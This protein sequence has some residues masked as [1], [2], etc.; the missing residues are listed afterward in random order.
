MKNHFYIIENKIIY[1]I[2]LMILDI[3]FLQIKEKIVLIIKKL[4]E[5]YLILLKIFLMKNKI[6]K[7]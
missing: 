6:V 1:Q 4:I 5:K 3:I 7:K 2:Q